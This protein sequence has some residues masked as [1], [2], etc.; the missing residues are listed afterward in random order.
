M[1]LT[2]ISTGGV[3]DDA[4]T[5]AKI[6]A[7]QIE[8]SELADNAVDTNAIADNAVSSAKIPTDA[9]TQA[10]INIPLSNRNLV[11]NGAMQVA[12]RGTSTSNIS[13]TGYYAVD[14]MRL[15][16]FVGAERYTVTQET[17]APT[18]SGFTK[19]FKIK[20]STADTTPN[21]GTFAQ[22]S[23]GIEGQD[24]QH[25]CKGT[26]SAKTINISFWVK[27]NTNYTPVAELKETTNVRINVQTFNVTTSWTK[28]I[29]SY[30]ADTA[31]GAIDND[32]TVGMQFNIWLKASNYYSAGTSPTQNTWAAQTNQNIRAALLTFDIAASTDNYFQITG[33]QIEV[34]NPTGVVTEFEHRSFGQELALCQRYFQEYSHATY[35]G[36]GGFCG[37]KSGSSTV[38][39]TI[40]GFPPMRAGATGSVDN[41]AGFKLFRYSDG[42]TTTPTNIAISHEG[43]KEPFTDVKFTCTV[44]SFASTGNMCGMFTS[45]TSGKFTLDAEL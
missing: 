7:N 36:A 38:V 4:I 41:L 33:L 1:P 21:T 45:N 35:R 16:C 19:S 23:Y 31:G 37:R 28:V 12:Q 43:S 5:K 10:K 30:V 34:G 44:S 9:I 14:R 3:K 40:H 13:S 32:N 15:A 42:S 17:D 24:L 39:G 2:Q 11:I 18:G 29:L 8:A 22:F 26:S 25:L 27:G 20:T 6:P